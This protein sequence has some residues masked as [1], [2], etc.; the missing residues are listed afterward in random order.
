M[1][2]I[3]VN[4][5]TL[6]MVPTYKPS[7]YHQAPPAR[8]TSV[9]SSVPPCIPSTPSPDNN[10]SMIPP[11]SPLAIIKLP[12][13]SCFSS[14]L[15]SINR[16]PQTTMTLWYPSISHLAINKLP[17]HGWHLLFRFLVVMVVFHQLPSP[18]HNDSM[19]TTYKPSCYQ[20]APLAR[21]TS[22]VSVPPC[23]LSTPLSRPQWLY[24]AHL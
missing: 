3:L 12:D 14:S 21:Q 9:V 24:D 8:Q 19:I 6:S 17:L 20:Q 18:D 2:A 16:P 5:M 15:H 23:I 10:D 22:V 1:A 7:C 4:T 13:T 11:I